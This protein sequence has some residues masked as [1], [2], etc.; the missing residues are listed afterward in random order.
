M[1]LAAWPRSEK[2]NRGRTCSCEGSE[3]NRCQYRSLRVKAVVRGVLAPVAALHNPLLPADAAQLRAGASGIDRPGAAV[4]WDDGR[5][6]GDAEGAEGYVR[7][8]I[9]EHSNTPPEHPV[10]TL[11]AG[12]EFAGLVLAFCGEVR[13]RCPVGAMG[14]TSP[15]RVLNELLQA[16]LVV[17]Q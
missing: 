7:L 9:A 16:R 10:P 11:R 12:V 3:K 17:R 5:E 2:R 6:G 8:G 1:T 15:V 13:A 14:G 4:T